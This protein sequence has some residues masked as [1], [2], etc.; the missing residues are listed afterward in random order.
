[1]VALQTR[2]DRNEDTSGGV[3]GEAALYWVFGDEASSVCTRVSNGSV[4]QAAALYWAPKAQD[5]IVTPCDEAREH[6][7]HTPYKNDIEQIMII[8]AG[9]MVN[10]DSI[11][12]SMK[13]P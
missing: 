8:R 7:K 11:G 2:D 4:R 9:S 6:G 3:R 1:M 12:Q 5:G 10:H 13:L